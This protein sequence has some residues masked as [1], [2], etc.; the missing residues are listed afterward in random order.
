MVTSYSGIL[1]ARIFVG[2]PEVR[3]PRYISLSFPQTYRTIQAAFYPG[4]IYLLSR[5]YTRK[6]WAVFHFWNIPLIHD[7]GLQELAF[8]S[9]FLYGGLLI[10]N[11]FGSVS[12]DAGVFG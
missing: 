4:A 10:S 5:W 8:R 12:S 7:P 1:V 3:D 2:V 11:A 9:A 6:V